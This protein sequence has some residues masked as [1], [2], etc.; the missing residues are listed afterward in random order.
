MEQAKPSRP[1]VQLSPASVR[2][3]A[4]NERWLSEARLFATPGQPGFAQA[5]D[6]LRPGPLLVAVV[7]ESVN[8]LSRHSE[9]ELF[10]LI[11]ACERLRVYWRYVELV[12]IGEL[13]RRHLAA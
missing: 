7:E 4:E 3:D 8:D 1:A 6:S 9:G 13:A 10:A 12:M 5:V 2:A 11:R